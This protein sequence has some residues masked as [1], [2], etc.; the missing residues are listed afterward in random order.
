M[1]SNCL[2]K[3]SGKCSVESLGFKE[4][5]IEDQKKRKNILKEILEEL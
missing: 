3:C 5:S 2:K 1:K 4:G